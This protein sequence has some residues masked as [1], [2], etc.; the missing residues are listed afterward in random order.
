MLYRRTFAGTMA[1]VFREDTNHGEVFLA[2]TNRRSFL[3]SVAVVMSAF[4]VI[5][6]HEAISLSVF[7]RH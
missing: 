4:A 7:F 5:A 6:R 1:L 3:H 2:M